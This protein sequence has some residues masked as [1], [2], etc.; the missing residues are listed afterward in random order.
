MV[1][2]FCLLSVKG[3]PANVR[4]QSVSVVEWMHRDGRWQYYNASVMRGLDGSDCYSHTCGK[5]KVDKKEVEKQ[6]VDKQKVEKQKADANQVKE[7][8]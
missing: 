8:G 6:K 3:R 2:V 5:Q 1:A 4:R 7:C